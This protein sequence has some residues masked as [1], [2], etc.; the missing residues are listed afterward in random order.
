MRNNCA[1]ANF[2]GFEDIG[3]LTPNTLWREHGTGS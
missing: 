2:K 1:F 3:F